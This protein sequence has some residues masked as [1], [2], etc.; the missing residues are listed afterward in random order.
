MQVKQSPIHAAVRF[1]LGPRP[2]EL[3]G[4]AGDPTAW[5]AGQLSD[6]GALPSAF[7][8]MD[9]SNSRTAAL[10]ATRDKGGGV[11]EQYIRT[12]AAP[13]FLADLGRFLAAAIESE[14][15]FVERLAIFWANHFTVSVE[16]PAVYGLVVPFYAEA[17]RP[18]LG[19]RFAQMLIAATR[20]QAMLLYLDNAVSFGPNSK[21]GR[22]KGLGLNEN[23]ARELLELH[24]LGVDGG[25]TQADVGQLALILT[26]WT[27][28][29]PRD[30]VPGAF[31]FAAAGHEPG[32]KTLLG[33]RFAENGE[34]EG[35]AALEFLAAQPATARHLA[36]KLARH[37]IAD[38]PPD[39]AVRE[40]TEVFLATDGDLPSLH[41]ALFEMEAAWA[42][43]LFKLRT[44]L[45]LV[46]AALRA[47]G[48]SD[49]QALRGAIGSLKELGQMPFAALSPAGYADRALAWAAP[50]QV[51]RRV[52]WS[53]AAGDRLARVVEPDSYLATGLADFADAE[54]R[55]QVKNAPS[56]AEAL[57]MILAS[58]A[59]QRR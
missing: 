33:R 6:A 22:W 43:P 29:R 48:R 11:I 13:A 28:Q 26:G 57:A 14:R 17:I 37:F 8:G 3:A 15:P 16:R 54:L 31:Q 47:L 36:L 45:D 23:L 10:L 18:R 21:A 1:G 42:Q 2:G 7:D 20:H 53:A 5:L 56:R 51:L 32:P 40:L 12:Q 59:F 25:Y 46:L 30:P 41:R 50:D 38:D 19:G 55:F 27:L 4:I 9:D 24:T 44:P 35:L 52:D 58:P 39:E 49:R 34:A